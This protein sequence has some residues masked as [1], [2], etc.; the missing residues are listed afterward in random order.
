ME[1]CKPGEMGEG[2]EYLKNPSVILFYVNT[3]LTLF[4]L[5]PFTFAG[6]VNFKMRNR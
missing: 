5:K 3:A 4:L 6:I 1:I 2:Y